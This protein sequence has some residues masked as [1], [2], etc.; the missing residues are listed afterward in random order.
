M[1][2]ARRCRLFLSAGWATFSSVRTG[3]ADTHEGKRRR[4]VPEKQPLQLRAFENNFFSN[5]DEL[6]A[7]RLEIPIRYPF[8]N[9][10][11]PPIPI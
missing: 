1:P 9:A 3:R 6:T 7:H 2:A 5:V 10:A 11:V 8:K 4:F